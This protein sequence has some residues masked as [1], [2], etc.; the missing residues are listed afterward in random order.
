MRLPLR[1]A[2]VAAALLALAGLACSETTTGG[3]DPP[4]TP[5][6]LIYRVEASGEPDLPAGV[7]LSWDDVPDA[8]LESYRIYSRGGTGSAF[9]LRGV[10]TSN[11]FHDN[12]VPHLE[13]FVTAV[14]TDGDE[15]NGS[16]VV[17][18]DEFLDLERPADLSGTSLN[19][20]IHLLWTDNAFLTDPARFD[21]Y[22][23]YSASY[24]RGQNL[25]GAD[26]ALEGTTV[27]PE[28]LVGALPNGVPRCYGVSAVSRR[29]YESLWSP[30]WQ[31]TPRPDARNLIIFAFDDSAEASGFRFWQDLDNDGQLDDA[32]L[33]LVVD[34]NR[35]DI[36]FWIYRD[37]A[38]SSLW[39]QPEF[40]GT[41]M[42]VYGAVGDL[43]DIDLAPSGGY[44]SGPVEAVPGY[45][46]VFRIAEP[47]GTRYAGIRV[48]HVGRRYL[49]F[50]WSL[51]TDPDNPELIVRAG[52]PTVILSGTGVPGSQ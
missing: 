12:G 26:W 6:N 31:D 5:Q 2:P 3:G 29:G 7:L 21:W 50:D 42:Q 11:T 18:I 48:T 8:N 46:Y 1:L 24:E 23:V 4:A 35:T 32:E 52:L 44:G 41:T 40:T 34:G 16:N 30:L 13:Y 28:F 47:S 38:D 45:G 49:L 36:D 51:Q 25:C 37:P 10:T 39:F 27:A 14:D 20:A 15:S 9:G 22:R 43:T 19:R 33:G 17:R